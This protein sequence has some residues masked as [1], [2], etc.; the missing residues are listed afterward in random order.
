MKN[1]ALKVLSVLS[2]FAI[3]GT[4]AATTACP[5]ADGEGEGEGE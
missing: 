1:I 2:V 3:L 4:V 5:P